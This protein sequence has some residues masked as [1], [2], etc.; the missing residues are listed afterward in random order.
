MF[1]VAFMAF[2]VDKLSKLACAGERRIDLYDMVVSLTPLRI[3][4]REAGIL[5]NSGTR[6]THEKD[7][8]AFWAKIVGR[9]AN[10]ESSDI[11][12]LG[13]LKSAVQTATP[14]TM[15]FYH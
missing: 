15:F 11:K 4:E 6:R 13:R 1:A 8:S 9:D 3:S 2:H 5:G 12:K 14:G 7:M 10:Q